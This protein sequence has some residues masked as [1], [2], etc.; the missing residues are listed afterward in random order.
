MF[1]WKTYLFYTDIAPVFA[2]LFQPKSVAMF[3]NVTSDTAIFELVVTDKDQTI[4][5][6]TVTIASQTP[7]EK[8]RLD[9]LILKPKADA[10][11][12]G[13]AQSEFEIKFK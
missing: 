1:Q 13:A 12:D 11:F 8:F 3:D 4:D 7:E 6:L 5:E 10:T 9:G 2:N